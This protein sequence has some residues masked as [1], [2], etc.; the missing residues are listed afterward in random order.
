MKLAWPGRGSAGKADGPGPSGDVAV[1][2]WCRDV[3][4][5]VGALEDET[6]A[7][8]DDVLRSR[9]ADLRHRLADGESPD[10][11][12]PEAFATVREAARRTLGQRHHDVQIMGGAV[13]HLGKIAQCAPVREKP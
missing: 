3:V 2:R 12:L 1:L 7:C 5:F 13:L 10:V 4:V 11:L 6:A 8:S 9:T